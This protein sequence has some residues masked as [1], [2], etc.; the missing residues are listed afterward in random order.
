MRTPLLLTLAIVLA[1]N[2]V[3]IPGKRAQIYAA[4]A[5]TL[6]G[7]WDS[8]KTLKPTSAELSVAAQL[9]F[10]GRLCVGLLELR[11]DDIDS[12]RPEVAALLSRAWGGRPDA[13]GTGALAFLEFTARRSG[14]LSVNSSNVY[15][16]P[17]RGFLEF[18]AARELAESGD[19]ATVLRHLKDEPWREVALLFVSSLASC[20]EFAS[21]FFDSRTDLDDWDMEVLAAILTDGTDL[22]VD[23]LGR[24]KDTLE[25]HVGQ[26][27]SANA[28]VSPHLI[29][30]VFTGDPPKWVS[31]CAHALTNGPGTLSPIVAADMLV[32]LGTTGSL[33]TLETC[34]IAPDKRR[35]LV[36]VDA[37]GRHPDADAVAVLWNLALTSDLGDAA[38]EAL[39]SRGDAVAASCHDILRRPT[40]DARLLG[41]AIAVLCRLGDPTAVPQLLE[42]ARRAEPNIKYEILLRIKQA[43]FPNAQDD[44]LVRAA[45]PSSFYVSI[46]KRIVDVI[47]ALV[48]IVIAMPAMALASVLIKLDSRGPI[49]FRQIRVGRSGQSFT[50]LKF[51][52]MRSDTEETGPIWASVRDPR[53]TRAGSLLRRTRLDELPGLINILIGDMSLVGPRP[54]RTE[55]YDMLTEHVPF[56]EGRVSLKP[57][58]TGLAQVQ[59]KYGVSIE[60]IREKAQYDIS[61]VLR[62]SLWLD[63]WILIKTV[64]IVL[65]ARASE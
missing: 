65:F 22:E 48:G 1:L 11:L 34:L 44:L 62:C 33:R 55:Y 9:Q 28:P 61:Y 24:L 51:R 37:L 45:A 19:H 15:G 43:F 63:I 47:V 7:E 31:I 13:N 21:I 5:G 59:Y 27:L 35:R 10:L 26:Q 50:L 39:A 29:R 56:Y 57:G 12:R 32:T 49:M 2:N 36:V 41:S 6:L 53:V 38:I 14:L 3:A 18:F 54:E 4:I 60:D 8:V 16:F 40:A 52:T 64:Q 46:G 58:M 25:A 42:I 30:A 17:F 20:T 23:M